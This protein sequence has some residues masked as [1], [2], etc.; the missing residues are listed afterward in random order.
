MKLPSP[1][2]DLLQ[3]IIL[4]IPN[5][6]VLV[7]WVVMGPDPTQAYFW[8]AENKRLTRLWPGY[9]L[10]RPEEIFFVPEGKNWKIWR[11]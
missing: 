3:D 8:P 10:T 1:L 5:E 2:S 11:F 6:K 9:F 4:T 7:L